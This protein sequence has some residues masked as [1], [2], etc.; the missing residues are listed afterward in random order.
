MASFAEPYAADSSLGSNE[1][2]YG[3]VPA[4]R[5]DAAIQTG[6]DMPVGIDESITAVDI[7]SSPQKLHEASRKRSFFRREK[8]VAL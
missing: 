5:N 2:A 6:K 4:P 8:K 7:S 1:S 3:N